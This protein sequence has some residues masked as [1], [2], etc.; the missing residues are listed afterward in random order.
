MSA[1]APPALEL[2]IDESLSG[3]WAPAL[4]RSRSPVPLLVACGS[5]VVGWRVVA[6][7]LVGLVSRP[8]FEPLLALC[9][10]AAGLI[11][12]W[13][14]VQRDPRWRTLEAHEVAWLRADAPRRPAP[15]AARQAASGGSGPLL[16]LIAAAACLLAPPLHALAAVAVI[17][18][19]L[20]IASRLGW[21]HPSAQLLVWPDRLALIDGQA[22]LPLHLDDVV[23]ASRRDGAL[24]LATRGGPSLSIATALREPDDAAAAA[25]DTEPAWLAEL[26]A[27]L[28]A[29][30][31]EALR[32]GELLTHNDPPWRR[33]RS[34]LTLLV[35]G[36][37]GI[38]LAWMTA[39]SDPGALPVVFVLMLLPLV[40]VLVADPPRL[41]IDA[42][43]LHGRHGQTLRWGP[44]L[45]C[46]AA[47]ASYQLADGAQS[48]RVPAAAPDACLLPA[49]CRAMA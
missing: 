35:V 31:A 39:N 14:W 41:T 13:L 38:G 2:S 16:L 45:R 5:L 15:P 29:R 11:L 47:G 1:T 46:Q 22:V 21:L 18:A 49:L 40:V 37:V 48:L 19:P 42:E 43:G 4:P 24:Q 6:D 9:L 44:G 27:A 23:S 20:L 33:L 30:R 7:A 26:L 8:A 28:A 12:L 34:G 10:A 17:L 32:A 25:D 3:L 36:L